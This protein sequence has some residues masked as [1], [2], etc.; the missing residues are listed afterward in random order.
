[1]VPTDEYLH[2]FG[3]DF[4]SMDKTFTLFVTK[5]TSRTY[6]WNF[7]PIIGFLIL[8]LI[9]VFASS[10]TLIEQ[11]NR[12]FIKKNYQKAL[13]HYRNHLKE[14]PGEINTWS[15][16]G[17]SYYHSNQFKRALR[18]LRKVRGK[19]KDGASQ[20][21]YY[22][23]LT[24]DALN[25]PDL[26]RRFLTI[27]SEINDIFGSFA[28]VELAGFD[29]DSQNFEGAKKWAKKYIKSF[30]KENYYEAM[31]KLVKN[32]SKG[33]YAPLDYTQRQQRIADIF[34]NHDLS[35]SH[36]PHYWLFQTGFNY[37]A[38]LQS[39]PAIDENGEYA[40]T[41]GS[42]EETSLTLIG[43]LGYGPKI[44]N[45]ATLN[46]GYLYTQN[47]FTDSLR[48][49][50]YL[51]DP[52]DIS[53]FP[54][55]PDLLQRSHKIYSDVSTKF[56]PLLEL[57]VYG[58][59]DFVRGGSG[60]LPAPERPEIKK[61]VNI[62]QNSTIIPWLKF[63]IGTKSAVGFYLQMIKNLDLDQSEFSYQT[64][65]LTSKSPFLSYG[66]SYETQTSTNNLEF[67]SEFY[68]HR[69]MSNDYWEEYARRGVYFRAI[70]RWSSKINIMAKGSSYTDIFLFDYIKSVSCEING[71]GDFETTGVTCPRYDSGY[72]AQGG[73]S[74]NSSPN[75]YWSIYAGMKNH[76]NSQ[77]KLYDEFRYEFYFKYSWAFPSVGKSAK[78]LNY[79][80]G[81]INRQEVM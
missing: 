6:R 73:V 10:Q 68:Q 15:L 2:K 39:N 16:I 51:D 72:W 14:N 63:S 52:T 34:K 24:Y 26:A 12:A 11:G 9:P 53:Y 44:I 66:L 47:W 3:K 36:R 77:L 28:L 64:Y 49:S 76:S 74:Y 56:S 5:N 42:L 13:R 61:A 7:T 18:A 71:E 75:K 69:F 40:V 21:L 4:H 54:Y 25:Q 32:A 29:Y 70:Y 31:V 30:R 67:Y 22:L 35:I 60:I 1:M 80:S 43:G 37:A 23:G 20:N 55:R 46:M 59:L 33:F 65:S 57:G 78:Y 17:A 62:S 19:E 58:H 8:H 50:T 48:I 38:G 27:G 45:N 79:K 81:S 41:K